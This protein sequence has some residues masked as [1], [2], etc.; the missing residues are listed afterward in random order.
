[1]EHKYL[2]NKS[3]WQ[4]WFFQVSLNRYYFLAVFT[5]SS[6]EDIT[7]A[8]RNKNSK[9]KLSKNMLYYSHQMVIIVFGEKSKGYLFFLPKL[10]LWGRKMADQ[11]L[12][13]GSEGESREITTTETLDQLLES[14]IVTLISKN[15]NSYPVY[16]GNWEI[17]PSSLGNFFEELDCYLS[18]KDIGNITTINVYFGKKNQRIELEGLLPYGMILTRQPVPDIGELIA[19]NFTQYNIDENLLTGLMNDSGELLQQMMSFF[20]QCEQEPRIELIRFLAPVIVDAF[21]EGHL[22]KLVHETTGSEHFLRTHE[23]WGSGKRLPL[24]MGGTKSWVFKT[25]YGTEDTT[26]HSLVSWVLDQLALFMDEFNS[27]MA[28]PDRTSIL[29]RLIESGFEDLDTFTGTPIEWITQVEEAIK[30]F[31]F[32]EPQERRVRDFFRNEMKRYVAKVSIPSVI[33]VYM[34]MIHEKKGTDKEFEFIDTFGEYLQQAL[35]EILD[36]GAT[37]PEDPRIFVQSQFS[38]IF[39]EFRKQYEI[40]SQGAFNSLV[41][42]TLESIPELNL[43]Q[44]FLDSGYLRNCL[45]NSLTQLK[46][47]VSKKISYQKEQLAEKTQILDEEKIKI[48]E[49]R[50]ILSEKENILLERS[51]HLL[52]EKERINTRERKL[53]DEKDRWDEKEAELNTEE[54]KL[55]TEKQSIIQAQMTLNESVARLSTENQQLIAKQKTLTIEKGNAEEQLQQAAILGGEPSHERESLIRQIQDYETELTTVSELK[56][57][58]NN[59]L[60]A[61]EKER[62]VLD[63]RNSVLTARDDIWKK[64]IA[65]LHEAREKWSNNIQALKKEKE[66]LEENFASLEKD[67]THLNR[68]RTAWEADRRDLLEKVTELEQKKKTLEDTQAA[69]HEIIKFVRQKMEQEFGEIITYEVDEIANLVQKFRTKVPTYFEEACK[70]RGSIRIEEEWFTDI[71]QETPQNYK[72]TCEFEELKEHL[73]YWAS[74]VGGI[75][76]Q[77]IEIFLTKS[78]G[79]KTG[80]ALFL[81]QDQRSRYSQQIGAVMAKEMPEGT[82]L[83]R[84]LREICRQLS[85]HYDLLIKPETGE[86]NV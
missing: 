1:M 8:Y 43:P 77:R 73:R 64:E 60:A 28:Q 49:K 48:D 57:T 66:V 86:Q 55:E 14:G 10:F 79:R 9:D 62:S 22:K 50:Q 31:T 65:K 71:F 68:E 84:D 53:I 45:T 47:S 81:F 44:I 54:I 19:L 61:L 32:T 41:T 20:P 51:E 12:Q 15:G 85:E 18:T 78:G 36:Q 16:T 46:K 4:V 24:S 29:E 23:V 72:Q 2:H 42:K 59:G 26:L 5:E 3:S 13:P 74:P 83:L 75:Y 6:F 76:P 56:Q 21:R 63:E 39:T 25:V 67:R 30:D 7:K 82:L 11:S 80:Y 69:L 40:S 27:Y 37:V 17:I 34:K 58:L 35:I 33:R 70:S 38:G 52:S